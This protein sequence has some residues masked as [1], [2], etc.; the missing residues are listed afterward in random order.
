MGAEPSQARRAGC[1]PRPRA[2]GSPRPAHTPKSFPGSGS[3]KEEEAL[4]PPPPRSRCLAGARARPF[5]W[6]YRVAAAGLGGMGLVSRLGG[7]WRAWLGCALLGFALLG[8]LAQGAGKELGL[9]RVVGTFGKPVG[10]LEGRPWPP[11]SSFPN[12]KK[13]SPKCFKVLFL[14]SSRCRESAS[15]GGCGECAC[16]VCLKL[17]SWFFASSLPFLCAV[18][19]HS[20]PP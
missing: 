8:R 13:T 20:P 3:K 11:R 16:G 1:G 19:P 4:S 6:I 9:L 7:P 18:T 12:F 14:G 17:F 15:P 10:A 2:A 5:S